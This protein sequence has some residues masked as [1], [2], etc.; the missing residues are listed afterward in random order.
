M[1]SLCTPV[2]SLLVHLDLA[3][4][5]MHIPTHDISKGMCAMIDQKNS[6][7]TLKG[8]PTF[9]ARDY[10]YGLCTCTLEVEQRNTTILLA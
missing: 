3:H 10:T 1:Y 5:A 2:I 9:I 8:T 4:Y 6:A 7:T